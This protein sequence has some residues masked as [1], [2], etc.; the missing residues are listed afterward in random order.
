MVT[1]PS[2]KR[3]HGPLCRGTLSPMGDNDIQVLGKPSIDAGKVELGLAV[4]THTVLVHFDDRSS[5]G[6][7]KGAPVNMMRKA[8]QRAR[9]YRRSNLSEFEALFD[10]LDAGTR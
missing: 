7:A 6:C 10:Q 4:G 3:R 9:E 5:D 1:K 8:L 2:S